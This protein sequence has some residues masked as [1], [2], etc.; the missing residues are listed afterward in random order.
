M[1]PQKLFSSLHGPASLLGPGAFRLFLALVVFVDHASRL[2]LGPAAVKIFFCLSGFWI[3]RMWTER[4]VRAVSPLFTY[5]ASRGWRLIPTFALIALFTVAF[6]HFL[7][8]RSWVDLKGSAGWPQFVA[9]HLLIFGYGGLP[10]QPLMPAWSL[11]VEMQFYLVAPVLIALAARIGTPAFLAMAAAVSIGCA[12]WLAPHVSPTF[13]VFFALGIVAARQDWRPSSRLATAAGIVAVG[14]VIG[15]VLS[16]W[17]GTILGGIHRG[18]LFRYTEIVTTVVALAAFPYA[19]F[20]TRQR[21]GSRDGVFADFSYIVYLLHWTAIGWLGTVAGL[22]T[23]A[24]LGCFV[25]ALTATFAAAW[26]I[27]RLYDKPLNR[28]RARWVA[29]R[30]NRSPQATQPERKFPRQCPA[31]TSPPSP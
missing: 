24:R 10:V 22:P 7:L 27:W 17:R 4:Y 16:P 8:G 31:A 23:F 30:L 11:D 14:V 25:L 6:Q 1:R 2:A 21:G 18:P 12:L 28:A 3:Y 19:I 5:L 9:S 20:T 26:V 29:A 15:L 13:A